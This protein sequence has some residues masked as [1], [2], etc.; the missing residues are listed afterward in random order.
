MN[1]KRRDVMGMLA[2]MGAM[3]SL[4]LAQ[5][6]SVLPLDTPGLDHFDVIVP[7]VEKSARFYMGLFRTALHAQPFQGSQRYFILLGPLPDNRRVGYLAIGASRGRG[8]YIGHFCTSVANWRENGTAVTAQMK[9]EFRKAG[10]GEFPG[11]GGAA[12]TFKDPDG[13]E[14][15]FLPSPDTLVTAAV[16][17]PLVPPDQ[18]GVIEPQRVDRVLLRVSNLQKALA[19]YRILY[20]KESRSDARSAVFSFRNGSQIQMEEIAYVYGGGGPPRIARFGIFVKPFDR[21]AAAATI[22]KLGGKVVQDDGKVLRLTDVDGIE[23]E[24]VSG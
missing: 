1:H 4:S 22:A 24:L 23:L 20:G 17:S 13:I 19:Y 5:Q 7:D 10:F 15:Q 2:L 6:K 16:P 11:G 12:G 3:P 14:I 8:T 21:T 18:I 9:E